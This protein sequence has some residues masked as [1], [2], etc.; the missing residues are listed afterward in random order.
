MEWTVE[1]PRLD[2]PEESI[3]WRAKG[4]LRP[5]PP[6]PLADFAAARP[7]LFGGAFTWPVMVA[8]RTALDRNIAA[9]AG[10]ARDN[11]LSF[12][13]HGKTTMAPALFQ[14]QFDAGAW[15][16]TAATANQVVAYRRFRVPRV[17][18]ANELLDPAALAWLA[19]EL[20]AD[21]AFDALFYV[22]SAAG[23]RA[24]A[25]AMAARAWRR[26]LRVLV[27]IGFSGGRTGC[28]DVATAL[29]VARAAAAAPG[30]EV[31]GTA[32]Y[33]GGLRTAGEVA[34][35]VRDLVRAAGRM[36]ADGLVDGPPVVSV[37]GSAWFDV[38]AAELGGRTDVHPVLRSGAYIAHD[39]GTYAAGSPFHRTGGADALTGALE[40][41][42]QVLSVPE[43]GLAI[44]TMGKREANFDMGLP[45][46]RRLR[47]RGGAVRDAAGAE[48]TRLNDHHAYL[49]LPPD[50][51]PEPGDLV[52]FGISHPC[53][54]F[55]RW[56]FIPVVEDDDTVT[57]VLATYF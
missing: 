40:I 5:G 50:L 19:A 45:V 57:D 32:G 4:F 26:P 7:H 51:R 22:D 31:A 53:T 27:E 18:L 24:A 56:R 12:A 29:E 54:A 17:L 13:P 15:A 47:T 10:F 48:V 20:D 37:G 43:D 16:L 39:D 49:R 11:G 1:H 3:D 38:V 30:L 36:A 8:R 52:S 21:P 14:A 9:L 28:R 25:D 42:A 55:D 35:L 34:G 2:I 44:A 33:E 41:W 6:I 46:P 23:V